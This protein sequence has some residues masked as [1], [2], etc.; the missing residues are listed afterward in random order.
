MIPTDK[1]IRHLIPITGATDLGEHCMSWY[2][3][4]MVDQSVHPL[5]VLFQRELHSFGCWKLRQ[6]DHHRR[7]VDRCHPGSL[8]PGILVVDLRRENREI[9]SL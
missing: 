5:P 6:T 7:Q 9:T 3:G 2:D 1:Y 8:E 4:I